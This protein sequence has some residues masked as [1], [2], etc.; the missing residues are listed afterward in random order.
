MVT[1][2]VIEA[3]LEQRLSAQ[4]QVRQNPN[5]EERKCSSIPN[6]GAINIWLLMSEEK[7]ILLNGATFVILITLQGK[8]HA[9][10]SLPTQTGLGF[11]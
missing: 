10:S 9:Q 4:R 8:L 7:S 6:P 11:I 3:G 1:Y 5:T 2:K